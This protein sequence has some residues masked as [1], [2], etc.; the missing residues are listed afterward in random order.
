VVGEMPN[1]VDRVCEMPRLVGEMPSLE[2]QHPLQSDRSPLLPERHPTP[3]FFICDVFDSAPK[4][5]T[6]SMEHPLFTL[7]TK[8]D[9][10]VREYRNGSSYLKISP[11]N[12][13]LATVHDRDILIYCIS[14]CMARLNSGQQVHRTLRFNAHDLLKVTNRQTSKRGYKLFK[15][16]LERLQ[17]TR[18][19]TNITTGGQEHWEIF[20][21]IDGAKTVKETRDGRMQAIEIT[22][23]DWVFN[24]ISEKGGEIIT[25]SRDYFRL[26][27]P[28]ERRLY[29]LSRK[30][31]GQNQKWHLRLETI[32][33]RTGSNSTMKEFRR[34]LKSI[35]EDNSKHHHIPD[36]SF[37]MD[38]DLVIIR[39]RK[40]FSKTY[41]EPETADAIDK[42]RLKHS[43][44]D[45]ARKFAGG[46]DIYFLEG[47]WRDMLMT[48]RAIPEN[49]DGSFMGFVKWY[50][51]ENGTA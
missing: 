13:G 7:S 23:S 1:F 47:A 45:I 46:Y 11:S 12:L 26:R 20:S 25:I 30:M 50:V 35:I 4:S 8:P 24:A 40:D 36:Y 28:L 9:M 43:T 21:F 39:P 42:V 44:H 51:K 32:H 6:A 49:A 29:E 2:N 48:K 37:T 3:D 34:M 27:K 41:T 19:E 15:A 17:S 18:I 5:D 31:C 22:L 38:G 10:Q 33:A 14:Q 16:A